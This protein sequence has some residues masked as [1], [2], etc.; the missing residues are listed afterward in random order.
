MR[1]IPTLATAVPG[2]G[3]REAVAHAATCPSGTV[4]SWVVRALLIVA[5]IVTSWFVAEDA[6]NYSVIRMTIAILLIM[7][8]VFA[9]AFWPKHWTQ[10]LNRRFKGQEKPR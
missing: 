2:D 1:P 7:V 8:A 3:D 10:K 6:P 4:L 9:L 5:G